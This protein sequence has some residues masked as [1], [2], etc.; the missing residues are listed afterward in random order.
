MAVEGDVI[1]VRLQ[2]NVD[3]VATF[4]EMFFLLGDVGDD[5]SSLVA[6]QA[7]LLSYWD[8]VEAV[9]SP[10]VFLTCGVLFNWTT[11][12][13]E[14]IDFPVGFVGVASG[15]I[16]PQSQ[17]IR[18][19]LNAQ[20]DP[21]DPITSGGMSLSGVSKEF[22]ERGRLNDPTEFDILA[23][24]LQD[25]KQYGTGWNVT[26]VIRSTT[27]RG[28]HVGLSESSVLQALAGSFIDGAMV[29]DEVVNVNDRSVGTIT[30]NTTDSVTATL[31]SGNDNDWDNHD[32][33]GIANQP[34]Y[35]PVMRLVQVN[36]KFLKLRGRTLKVCG[37][38]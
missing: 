34:A 16:H 5:P 13:K 17:T 19:T 25:E 4:N 31:T 11:D 24:L 36:P 32:K 22:S 30:A 38:R 18:M 14:A 33:Y 2:T 37:G 20:T 8:A 9:M 10:S 21:Q 23:I 27:L 12:T 35:Y 1:S 26:P 15:G 7:I 3:G 28:F 6:L 29:G